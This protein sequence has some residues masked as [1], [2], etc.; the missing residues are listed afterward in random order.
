[1]TKMDLNCTFKLLVQ[2]KKREMNI[3]HKKKK[4]INR[5]NRISYSPSRYQSISAVSDIVC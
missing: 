3:G 2:I 5:S 1:M 4:K